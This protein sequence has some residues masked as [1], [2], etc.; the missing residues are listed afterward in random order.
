MGGSPNPF[1]G[2][3]M[4]KNLALLAALIAV[5]APGNFCQPAWA[6]KAKKEVN[7]GPSAMPLPKFYARHVEE[8]NKYLAQNRITEAMNEFLTAKSINPDY[9]PTYIGIAK[10]Y[11][12][13]GEFEKATGQY[14]LAIRLLNPSYAA[15]HVKR[16]EYFAARRRY[17]EALADY[18]EVLKIDPQAGNQYT[19]AMRQLRLGNQ[20][21]AIKA[22]ERATQIDDD[23]PDPYFQMGNL[24][25]QDKK[26]KKAIPF[27][28]KATELDPNNYTYHIS[29]GNA[30]YIEGTAKASK[31]DLKMV[32]DS[33]YHFERA[34]SLGARQPRVNFN[35]GTAYLLSGNYD[36]AIQNLQEALKRE[37]R[38]PDVYYNLGNA[39][40]KKALTINFKWD[41]RSSLTDPQQLQM[42]DR[43]FEYLYN[44]INSYEIALAK[45][46]TFTTTKCTNILSMQLFCRSQKL[47]SPEDYAPIYFDLGIAYYQLSQMKPTAPF[48]SKIINKGSSKE[49]FTRG[50]KYFKPDMQQR[51]LDNLQKFTSNSPD[52]KMKKSAGDMIT[53][54]KAMLA[55]YRL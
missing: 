6:Q 1:L 24:Q 10:A 43:K 22:F 25:F 46:D 41:E 50:L 36:G 21:E 28:Q 7:T 32:Q 20:K 2:A 52:A 30:L 19:L 40:Y 14:Q 48:I 27:Y 35:L 33:V 3:C 4:R 8:G 13:L 49:Y 42:N 15:D 16:G 29:L 53:D 47:K 54:I 51:A 45:M 18:W 11:I 39:F 55:E 9:Y 26:M 5:S 44:A 34:V 12:K 31:V 17:K 38:D 37:L 23:Y